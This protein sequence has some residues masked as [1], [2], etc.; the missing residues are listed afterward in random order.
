MTPGVEPGAAQLTEEELRAGVEEAHKASKRT[1]THA[2][3]TEGIKAAMRAGIDTV[4]HGIFLDDE[5][6]EMMLE[7][8]VVF[9]PT[10]A[11][12]YRIVEAGEDKGI[13]PYA[14]EK[15]RRVMDAHRRSFEWAAKAGVTIAAGNDG[16]T[17]FNPAHDLVTEIRLMAEWGLG[18][19]GAIRAATHGSAR[20]LGLSEETG[21]VQAGKW[22]DL[23]ILEK[24]ADPL[25]DISALGRVWMVVKQGKVAMTSNN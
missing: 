16:G 15:S 5:A 2:Q 24:D 20:A 7:R 11:A 19:A 21:T 10:L 4:E 6:I 18:N 17:P 9:V 13:P 23:L 3:G 22:A 12:P 14:L 8:G 25:Q 1:A